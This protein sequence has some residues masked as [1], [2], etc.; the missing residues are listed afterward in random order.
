VAPAWVEVLVED[1][2]T[3]MSEEVLAKALTPF[4]TT[5]DAGKGTGLGLSLVNTTVVAHKGQLELHSEIGQGTQVR[6]VFPALDAGEPATGAGLPKASL[7]APAARILDVLVV[8][9]DDLLLSSTQALIELEGHTVTCAASGEQALAR[10][11][12]GYRPGL[13][14]LDLNMPGLG[15]KGTLPRLRSLLPEVPILL[16]TGFAEPEDLAFIHATPKVTLLAKPFTM[17]ELQRHL[18]RVEAGG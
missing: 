18:R 13:V 7:A 17:K 10:V 15:G 9:D 12:E 5:K 14:I 8:D 1:T 16:A 4:F 3:G 2:G 11:A 6:M